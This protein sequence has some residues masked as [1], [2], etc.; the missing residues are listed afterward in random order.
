MTESKAFETGVT[1]TETTVTQPDTVIQLSGVT[2]R[3]QAQEILS[4]FNLAVHDGEFF[5]ILGPSGC[6]KTTVLRLI[7]GFEPFDEG[8]LMVAGQ[9]VTLVPA[10]R[11]PVNTVFQSYALFPH[12]SVFDNVAFGLKMAKVPKSEIQSRVDEALA[13]VQLQE[14]AARKPEQLS[15]GQKQRV[16]IARAVVNRP[17]VLLLDESL[18]ALDYKLRLQMQIELKQLQRKLGITFIYVTH[19]QEEA[20]SMS[21]RVL[22]MQDGRAQQVGTPR[23]IYESPANLFVA[24]FIGEINVFDGVVQRELGDFQYQ[25]LLSGR[26]TREV[27]TD[28]KYQEGDAVHVMLRPE[29]LRITSLHGEQK[30]VGFSG[31]VLERNYTGQTLDSLIQLDDG[32]QLKASEFFDED[33]PDFDYRINEAVWVDWVHGW[34]HVIP[35]QP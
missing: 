15:G 31:Q 28:R 17:R 24:R 25:V 10:E 9:D 27:R 30:R 22:V 21:D 5:T 18:S 23:Q 34:E 26:Y 35:K 32:Q 4:G 2:K 3:Y 14:F 1:E 11:R 8:S 6:G 16:A 29:D 7:A 13:M 12:L 33:D 20:L 19:D